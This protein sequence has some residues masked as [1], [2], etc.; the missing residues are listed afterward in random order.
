MWDLIG[1]II[2]LMCTSLNWLMIYISANGHTQSTS[3]H[4][5]YWL[6]KDIS[7]ARLVFTFAINCSKIIDVKLNLRLY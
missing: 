7:G 4:I 5:S 1:Q 2:E 6:S 3:A